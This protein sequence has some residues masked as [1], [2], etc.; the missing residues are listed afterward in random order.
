[1]QLLKNITYH[2]LDE[3]GDFAGE[4]NVE[5]GKY[6]MKKI[7]DRL[8]EQHSFTLN[9]GANWEDSLFAQ[10][11]DFA[12]N[13]VNGTI[14]VSVPTEFYPAGR[15]LMFFHKPMENA[16]VIHAS[17]GTVLK[18]GR[19]HIAACILHGISLPGC[20]CNPDANA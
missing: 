11:E 18:L 20:K 7:I 12:S 9:Q 10:S 3:I 2:N 1:M 5:Q 15:E 6:S 19:K 17:G 16:N 8:R 14:R 4:N 13:W